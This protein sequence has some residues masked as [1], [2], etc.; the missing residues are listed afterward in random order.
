MGYKVNFTDNQ[1]VTGSDINGISRSLDETA[2]TDFSDGVLYGVDALNGISASL[3]TS[4][5]RAGCDARLEDGI[6]TISSGEAYFADGKKIVIDSDGITLSAPEGKSY[7]WLSNDNVSGVVSA[8]CTSDVPSGDCVR[9]AEISDGILKKTKDI[10]RLKNGSLLPNCYKEFELK[11][12]GYDNVT[13]NTLDIGEN[14]RK[15][16]LICS[17][18]YPPDK[19]HGL[20]FFDWD[21]GKAYNYDGVPHEPSEMKIQL[22]SAELVIKSFENNVLTFSSVKHYSMDGNNSSV[23]RLI[24]M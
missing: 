2:M 8:K 1:N 11:A 17:D 9:L 15:M 6:V 14:Y 23:C 19:K 7:V 10:A 21:E 16:V 13:E 20:C 12:R 18:I 3:I 24:C 4:G 22:K 5:V